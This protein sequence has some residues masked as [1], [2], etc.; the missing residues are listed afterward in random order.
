MAKTKQRR[1]KH[2]ASS[3]AQPK[4]GVNLAESP[5]SWLYARGHLSRRQFDAG[6]ALRNDW[7]RAQFDGMTTMNW[8]AM[9]DSGQRRG[10]AEHLEPSEYAMAARRRFEEAL[11]AAGR[12]M[13]DLCW[14]VVCACESIPTV[15]KDLGWPA[16]SGKLVLRMALD[17]VADYYRIA[18][19]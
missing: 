4:P 17:R 11:A 15:E 1:T 18:G 8:S 12:D 19:E 3:P 5:V 10:P 13:N 16:R 14:R 7:E 9:I 6:E 2:S